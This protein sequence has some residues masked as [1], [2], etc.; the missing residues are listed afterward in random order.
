MSTLYYKVEGIDCAACA[1]ELL[2]EIGEL[3]GV[4]NCS[5]D[6]DDVSNLRFDY[7][8]NDEEQIESK[9]KKIIE[10]DQENPIIIKISEEDETVYAYRIHEIDCE[11]CAKKLSDKAKEIN[12]VSN[13]T[14][15]FEHE[16]LTITC[17]AKDRDSIEKQL[18]EMIHDTE[19]EVITVR[20]GEKLPHH[21][22]HEHHH[23]H[24]KHC[25][26]EHEHQEHEE[27]HGEYVYNV[28]GIDCAACAKELEEEIGKI[29]G[30][31]NC[32]LEFGVHSKLSYDYCGDN[33]QEVE[34]KMIKIIEDD[35]KN[36]VITRIE[37]NQDKTHVSYVVE[38]I[39][40]AACAKELEEEINKL[41]GVSN[42]S[43]EFGIKSKLNYDVESSKVNE[44]EKKMIKIIEDD[45]QNP[46]ITR[47]STEKEKTYKFN[48]KDIDCADCANELAEACGKISGVKSCEADFMNQLLIVKCDPKEKQRIASEMK[49][50]IAKAEPNVQFSEYVKEK[51]KV[52]DE[53]VNDK[54]ML[55]RLIVGAIFFIAAALTKENISWIFSLIAYVILGY[56]VLVKA[57][58]NM[59]RGQLFDEHFLM[60][61]ATLAAIYQKE[62]KE[63]AGV[64]LFYQIGEYFQDLAVRRSRK[65]IGELMDIRPDFAMVQRNGEYVKV[66]PDEVSIGEIIRVKPGERVPLD[67]KVVSGSSSL[68]TASLTG[69]SKLRDVDAGDEV[70][71]GSVNE[72]GVLEIEVTKEYGESTVAKILEL[73]ENND[74]T[75]AEHEKFIT[76]FS[77]YYTPIVVFLAVGVALF[78]GIFMGD[79]NE[80]VRRAC[81]F[82]VISCP[83]AL[84]ISIPL[85]FFAGIGG[86]SSRGV[87]VKGANVIDDLAKVK[88]VIMDKTGTLTSGT[89]AVE[90]A[91]GTD[92]SESIIKDAAYAE[93]FSNHP[94]AQGIKDAYKG[95]VQDSEVSDVEEIA[96]RGLSV[97]AN[98]STILAGNYKLMQDKNI[99]C[100][101]EQ[102]TGTLVYVA[103]DGKYEGCLVLRDQL[104]KDAK[105]AI[106]ELHK[107]GKKCVIV[108]GDNQ[109]ITDSVGDALG[110]DQ[111]IGGCLPE[112]KVNTVKK[113]MEDGMTA[114][115]GDGVNDAPVITLANV[116]FAMGALGSDAAIEA[117][118]VVLMDDSPSKISLAISASKRILFIANENIYGAI[119]IKVL[120]LIFGALGIANMWWAIFADTG[121]AMLCV[122]NSLR[123]LH[124]ARKK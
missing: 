82:L 94:I 114:F 5:L 79:F 35:Q 15:D 106:D 96:G 107:E 92:D 68:D 32:H 52:Q 121:V 73:V 118:D 108:S 77:K 63:A 111:A 8:G 45:Q 43:L 20:W 120:T 81:T 110:V 102:S 99:D 71:S 103:K 24:E 3:E 86:L 109:Q 116:G 117:A 23:E 89:F 91:I 22:H 55:A 29:D 112:D 88:Q 97:K 10:D 37:N 66:D 59:G 38:G 47:V 51:K 21:E 74:S 87:L 1:R 27:H 72:T 33:A 42:C 16:K 26:C 14:V 30:V 80:G 39:D 93:H 70:I 122:L 58:R 44:I 40:C 84:V 104:K 105:E 34:K 28:D 75:K 61:I 65:S 54:V 50:V 67:G 100:K 56:D 115:V 31:I 62:F 41:D 4:K 113:F 36:P 2:D 95:T 101:E 57:V 25:E 98:G 53:E 85:S 78:V 83:C 69:E 19:E 9:M 119:A 7:E 12:G 11:K 64:M 60:A 76:K 18:L 49:E 123:L 6:F 124:I 17:K 48:I 46:I 13:S 90:E